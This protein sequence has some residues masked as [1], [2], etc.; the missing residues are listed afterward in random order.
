MS[1]MDYPE[2]TAGYF[3]DQGL[4]PEPERLEIKLA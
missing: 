4:K 2:N 1:N 3:A